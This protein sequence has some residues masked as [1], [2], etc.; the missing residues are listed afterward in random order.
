VLAAQGE[1]EL[2]LREQLRDDLLEALDGRGRLHVVGQPLGQ[3]VD[4]DPVDLLVEL[5]VVELDVVRRLE[6]RGRAVA[7]PGAVGDRPLVG[8]GQDRG[9][10]R[11]E[12][13]LVGGNA[14]EVRVEK[15]AGMIVQ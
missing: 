14:Q 1:D 10:A 6:D 11:L 15:H 2:V 9:A 3:R 7:S 8:H 4:P 5:V 13:V 12:G